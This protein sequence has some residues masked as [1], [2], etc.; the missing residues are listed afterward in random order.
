MPST[1]RKRQGFAA[2]RFLITDHLPCRRVRHLY[3]VGKEIS[4]TFDYVPAHKVCLCLP[5]T[6]ARPRSPPPSKSATLEKVAPCSTRTP[7][8][9]LKSHRAPQPAKNVPVQLRKQPLGKEPSLTGRTTPTRF[10]MKREPPVCL[11]SKRI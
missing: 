6:P 1:F 8:I 7:G 5:R 3:I 9:S 4:V 11:W 10:V 2:V